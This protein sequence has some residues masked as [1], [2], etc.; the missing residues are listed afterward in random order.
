[1]C[2]Y[3]KK[4]HVIF[5]AVIALKK[6]IFGDYSVTCIFIGGITTVIFDDISNVLSTIY[7]RLMMYVPL[8]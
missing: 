3:Q 8:I 2:H 1:M 6:L 4:K 7:S 5:C